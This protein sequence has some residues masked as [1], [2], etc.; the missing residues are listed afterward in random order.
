MPLQHHEGPWG[1]A[2]TAIGNRVRIHRTVEG[3]HLQQIAITAVEISGLRGPGSCQDRRGLQQRTEQ[4]LQ[5]QQCPRQP[6]SIG[7]PNP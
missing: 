4:K 3:P 5:H 6:H 1:D 7:S 2:A